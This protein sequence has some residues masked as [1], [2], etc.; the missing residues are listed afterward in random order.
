MAPCGWSKDIHDWRGWK[1]VSLLRGTKLTYSMGVGSLA[2]GGE[3]QSGQ[4]FRIGSFDTEVDREVTH[5]EYVP[6]STV[7]MPDSEQQQRYSTNKA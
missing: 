2:N 6:S 3:P 7:L 4:T 5:E 1:S